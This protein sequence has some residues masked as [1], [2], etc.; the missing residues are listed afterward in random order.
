MIYFSV[1]EFNYCASRL[2]GDKFVSTVRNLVQD[3]KV[4]E[5]LQ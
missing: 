3:G 4:K 1:G 5:Y 2:D